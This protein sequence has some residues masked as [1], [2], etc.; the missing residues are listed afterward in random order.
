MIFRRVSAFQRISYMNISVRRM[1][2]DFFPNKI[3]LFPSDPAGGDLF[4]G[5]PKKLPG[6][7][8]AAPRVADTERHRQMLQ[9]RLFT[10][11]RVLK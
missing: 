8:L 3:R 4:A 6:R 10:F 7:G 5:R 11:K 2:Y 1:S 9:G